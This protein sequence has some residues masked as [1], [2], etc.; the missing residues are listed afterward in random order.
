MQAKAAQA[1]CVNFIEVSQAGHNKLNPF[2]D[3]KCSLLDVQ[4]HSAVLQ[5]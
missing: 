1:H 3:A 5:Q 2:S 4:T